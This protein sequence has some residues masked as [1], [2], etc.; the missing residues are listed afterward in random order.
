[1][2]N[3]T[4][5]MFET[6]GDGKSVLLKVTKIGLDQVELSHD[7]DGN[8]VV[9]PV[10]ESSKQS[11]PKYRLEPGGNDLWRLVL[12]RDIG[13]FKAG[14]RG[15]LVS[16]EDNL[17][18]VGEC[19]INE[20][21]VVTGGARVY[22]NA[23]VLDSTLEHRVTVCGNAVVNRVTFDGPGHAIIS[24]AAVVEETT[25][26][27]RSQIDIKGD[28][29]IA[30]S[31]LAAQ[32]NEEYTINGCDMEEADVTSPFEVLSTMT[33][34][35]WMTAFRD[36]DHELTI[37]VG[38]QSRGDVAAIRELAQ[39]CGATPVQLLMLEGF[40]QMVVAA[41]GTWEPVPRA[42]QAHLQSMKLANTTI[43]VDPGSRE[44]S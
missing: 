34:Y 23:L 14:S 26:V 36:T 21:S 3:E 22:G 24:G 27:S 44:R 18:Q 30:F 16:C 5:Y 2:I 41:M 8:V 38:C 4:R 35:G 40:L 19:W 25:I 12:L 6:G 20:Y 39:S 42:L 1:M 17:S 43:G 9:T 32:N 13:K 10:P 11:S 33:P 37:S 7:D 15:G 29:R 31:R 28:S